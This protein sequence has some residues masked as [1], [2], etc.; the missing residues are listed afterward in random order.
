MQLWYGVHLGVQVAGD[1]DDRRAQVGGPADERLNVVL[2]DPAGLLLGKRLAHVGVG[3]DEDDVFWR[4]VR[5]GLLEGGHLDLRPRR[6]RSEHQVLDVLGVGHLR[7]LLAVIMA[8]LS[9]HH[10]HAGLVDGLGQRGLV[11]LGTQLLESLLEFLPVERR[12]LPG[13]RAP[14]Q[15]EDASHG[16]LGRIGLAVHQPIQGDELVG[17]P[18]LCHPWQGVEAERIL[19][20]LDMERLDY[21]ACIHT[22]PFRSPLD[23]ELSIQLFSRNALDT[24]AVAGVTLLTLPL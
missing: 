23:G 13:N 11:V 9:L 5:L 18:R 17:S 7:Q 6:G 4:P 20:E 1:L 19:D 15:A 2:V 3:E 8:K 10:L 22:I 16:V 24:G 12:L 14:L 21:L